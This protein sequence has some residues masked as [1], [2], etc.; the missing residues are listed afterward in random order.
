MVYELPFFKSEY[1]GI[2]RRK[3]DP[4]FEDAAFWREARD[5]Y[6]SKNGF[7]FYCIRSML[8]CGAKIAHEDPMTLSLDFRALLSC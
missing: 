8:K 5:I 2:G 3:A 4:F 1:I 6:L 7:E